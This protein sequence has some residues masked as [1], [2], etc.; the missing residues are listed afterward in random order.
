MIYKHPFWIGISCFHVSIDIVSYE[1]CDER[2]DYDFDIVNFPFVDANISRSSSCGLN[3][4]ELTWIAVLSSF[5][6]CL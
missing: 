1:I 5:Y 3:N 6:L 4:S 2:D